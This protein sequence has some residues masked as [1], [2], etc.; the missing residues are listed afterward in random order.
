MKGRGSKGGERGVYVVEFFQVTLVGW[1]EPHHM[2]LLRFCP[3]EVRETET[4]PCIQVWA[5]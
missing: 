5:L 4:F 3:A 1:L 2:V